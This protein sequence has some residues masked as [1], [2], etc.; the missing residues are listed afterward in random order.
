MSMAEIFSESRQLL[1]P[2]YSGL[3]TAAI[4][5]GVLAVGIC[6]FRFFTADDPSQMKKALAAIGLTA[7][8]L[9]L[10]FMAPLVVGLIAQCAERLA[11]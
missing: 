1:S 4:P 8:A 9:A 5:L 3:L 10:F 11:A 7:A 6:G 2:L